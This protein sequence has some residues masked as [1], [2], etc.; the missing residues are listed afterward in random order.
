[1]QFVTDIKP[2]DYENFVSHHPTKSHFMQSFYWGEI[3]KN[4][5]FIPHYVGLIDNNGIVAAAL[6]LEKDGKGS[7]TFFYI[8][9][10]FVLDFNNHELIKTFTAHI[11]NF[12]KKRKAFFIRID[13]DIKLQNLDNDGKII[14]EE[15]NYGL[16]D[17]LISLGYK[18]RGFN[19]N[20][21]HN[22]PRYT[23]RL[24]LTPT[25]EEINSNFHLTTRKIISKGNPYQI[26]IYKGGNDQ[27]FDSFYKTMMETASREKIHFLPLDYY[28]KFYHVFHEHGMSDL[29][30]A[31]VNIKNL[32]TIYTDKIIE[33]N[34]EI[35]ELEYAKNR[36]KE[37]TEHLKGE[38]INQR[39]KLVIELDNIK[40]IKEEELVLSSIITVKY[41]DKVWTVHGGNLS[42]LRELN[43]NYLLY[44]HIL[45]DAK[46]DGYK[47]ID[48]FG[49]TGNP[50]NNNS[51]YGIHLFKKRFGGELMEFIGEFDLVTNKLLYFIYTTILPRIKKK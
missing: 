43:T 14:N 50:D 23:F 41:D 40:Q 3:C 45:R 26:D 18:H 24:D 32:I 10:G 7:F 16:V 5:N 11:K 1:M 35:M 48:F 39:N 47:K 4:K 31:K 46:Q 6:I 19:K 22:Q 42:I 30:L 37:K 13:P 44:Y 33:V 17:F 34:K 27:D 12:A 25:I 8:P 38:L 9:R 29:Y 28:K 21:E 20:F 49:T 15:N 2:E 36:N 51:V